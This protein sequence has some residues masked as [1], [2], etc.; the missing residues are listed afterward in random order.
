MFLFYALPAVPFMCLG[1]AL[2]A[3][4][5]LGGH[6]ASA[7]RRSISAMGLGVYLAVVV[8]NFAYLYPILAAQTLPY[9]TG[10]PGCGSPAGSELTREGPVPGGTGPSSCGWS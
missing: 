3:G 2:V 4:W 10:S 9:P 6:H 8:I 1:I 5:L 7:R